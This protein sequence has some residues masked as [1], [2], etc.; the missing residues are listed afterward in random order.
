MV[1]EASGGLSSLALPSGRALLGIIISVT[2]TGSKIP[3]T[4]P[5]GTGLEAGVSSTKE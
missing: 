5:G 2:F 4:P 1:E 3:G